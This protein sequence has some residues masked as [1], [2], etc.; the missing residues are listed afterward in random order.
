[1]NIKNLNKD[2]DIFLNV[3]YLCKKLIYNNNLI[4]K[5]K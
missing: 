4:I 2:V 1:M 5:L 3:L